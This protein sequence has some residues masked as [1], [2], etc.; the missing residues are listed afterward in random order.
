MTSSSSDEELLIMDNPLLR[1][2]RKREGIHPINRKRAE[3]GEYH[4]PFKEIK[5]HPE[6][7]FQYMRMTMDTFSYI[8]QKVEDRLNKTWCNLHKQPILPEE[9]LV[10]KFVNFPL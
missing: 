2:K 1:L 10:V 9:R 3:Y 8:L 6:R 4:H 5:N 7:F